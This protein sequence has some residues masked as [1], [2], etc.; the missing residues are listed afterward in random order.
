MNLEVKSLIIKVTNNFCEKFTKIYKLQFYRS[1]AN[2]VQVT[3]SDTILKCK[4]ILNSRFDKKMNHS[5]PNILLFCII[6]G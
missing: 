1:L 4:C 5:N 3:V 6:L 2:S